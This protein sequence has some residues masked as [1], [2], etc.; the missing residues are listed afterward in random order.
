MVA[1]SGEWTL[2][3]IANL[4]DLPSANSF[5]TMFHMFQNN[6]VQLMN[7]YRPSTAKVNVHA[8]SSAI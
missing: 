4:K 3:V 7:C 8:T 5:G 2:N 1:K 6:E